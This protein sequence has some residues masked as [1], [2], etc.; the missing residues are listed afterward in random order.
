MV[1]VDPHAVVVAELSEDATPPPEDDEDLW[2]EA[3]GSM[4][5]IM[6][7]FGKK[8]VKFARHLL[9]ISNSLANVLFN[10]LFESSRVWT[11]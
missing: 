10:E 11:A 3:G 2:W 8:A 7:D 4:C 6:E 5:P 9:P 1:P